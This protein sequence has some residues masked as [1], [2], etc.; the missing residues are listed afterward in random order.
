MDT[1]NFEKELWLAFAAG[2]M[3]GMSGLVIANKL[4]WLVMP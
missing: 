2:M 4:D 1:D 3:Y